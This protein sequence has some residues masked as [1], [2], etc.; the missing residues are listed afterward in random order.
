MAKATSPSRTPLHLSTEELPP[1]ARQDVL[2]DVYRQNLL[3]LGIEPIG[4]APWRADV[5]IRQVDACTISTASGTACRYLR[6]REH[7]QRDNDKVILV[8]VQQGRM[9]VS[10]QGREAIFTAGQAFTLSTEETGTLSLLDQVQY[11]SVFIPRQNLRQIVPDLDTA[12]TRPLNGA[13]APLPLLVGYASMLQSKAQPLDNALEH[14]IANHLCD[15][16][17]STLDASRD[18]AA[19]TE[20]RSLRA[21]RLRSIRGFI[22]SHLTDRDLTVDLVAAH[23]KISPSYV[24]KLLESDGTSFADLVLELRLA[25]AH[26]LLGDPRRLGQQ[27]GVIAYDVGFGDLSYFNRCFR[28]RYGMTP[29]ERRAEAQT[30]ATG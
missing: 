10:Q 27:I 12:L 26:R 25:R 5:Q 9:H 3:A 21:V 24:R 1:T 13:I 18:V 17:A 16:V 23:H 19:A 14:S 2:E 28:R 22:V 4:D 30:R 8:A 20:D 15:L 7:L 6:E 11:T 29:S